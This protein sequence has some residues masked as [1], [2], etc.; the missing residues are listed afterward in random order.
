MVAGASSL[1]IES[2]EEPVKPGRRHV[3]QIGASAI[4]AAACP[5]F[6][7]AQ[8]Y[9]N[10]AVRIVAGYPPGSAADV[11]ARLMG[12]WLTERLGQTFIVEN[13]PGAGNNLATEAVA[14]APADGYTLLLSTSANAINATLYDKLNFNFLRDIAPA[15]SLVR[16]PLVLEVTPSLPARTVPELIAHA[17]DNPRKL[18]MASSG[19]GT[20]AHVAGELFKMQAGIDMVHVPYRGSPPALTDLIG[21][22]VQ[23]LFDPMLSSVDFIKAGRL[24]PLAVTTAARWEGLPEVPAMAEFI[25]GFEASLWLG[26]GAPR[27]T[28]PD[29]IGKLN[30]EINTA[31]ADT[32][33]RTRLA[34]LGATVFPLSPSEFGKFVADDTE[35]WS[36]V[37]KFSGAKAD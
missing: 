4:A 34:G 8:A 18:N 33:M 25:P 13:R 22:Q 20:V 37:V 30:T 26:L 15:A 27:N 1:T 19:N 29:V 6:A 31:L 17:K 32:K 23:V 14:N 28:P 7:W 16:G 36:K 10:R 35:K 11:M 3:L 24:R 21:G 12:Q 5:R 9:P 2:G